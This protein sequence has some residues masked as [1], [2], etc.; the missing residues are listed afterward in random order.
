MLYKTGRIYKI[1]HNQ[2][3]FCYVG[4]TFNQVRHRWQKHKDS[5]KYCKHKCSI[6]KYFD[7]YGIKNFKCILIKEYSVVDR[8]HLRAIEQIW[9]NKLNSI[10]KNNSIPFLW[11]DKKQLYY[12]VNN[13]KKISERG[14]LYRERNRD[15]I[16]KKK[17]E[18]RKKNGKKLCDKSKKYYQKNKERVRERGYIYRRKNKDKIKKYKSEKIKCECGQIIARNSKYRHVK[19]QKHIKKLQ[20]LNC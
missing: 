9:I 8:K 4:S 20:S 19:T 10:N 2:S 17:S 3:N 1:I 7:K 14:K 5:H 12:R 11:M 16:R 6:S 15:K 18:Y 13:K